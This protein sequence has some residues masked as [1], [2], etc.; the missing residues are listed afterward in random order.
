MRGI[1]LGKLLKFLERGRGKIMRKKVGNIGLYKECGNF[2]SMA[3]GRVKM[4]GLFP[5]D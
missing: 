5:Y 4:L 1:R 2:E 3:A